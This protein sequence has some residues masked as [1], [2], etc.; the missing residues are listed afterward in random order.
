ML[1]V[2]GP[3]KPPAMPLLPAPVSDMVAVS[4]NAAGARNNTAAALVTNKILKVFVMGPRLSRFSTGGLSD[5]QI[6][7]VSAETLRGRPILPT[8]TNLQRP[9]KPDNMHVF[10]H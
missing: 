8:S 4:A 1:A 10:S 3:T 9:P 2:Y 7:D 6:S 5:P